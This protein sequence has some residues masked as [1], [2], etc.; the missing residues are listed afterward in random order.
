MEDLSALHDPVGDPVGLRRIQQRVVTRAL[1]DQPG[2]EKLGID[3]LLDV[4]D[5]AV[6]PHRHRVDRVARRPQ[7]LAGDIGQQIGRQAGV[8][9]G[10]A[11]AIAGGVTIDHGARRVGDLGQGSL[12]GQA[13]QRVGEVMA[14]A[15]AD[16]GADQPVDDGALQQH[17]AETRREIGEERGEAVV[18]VRM[19]QD[20]DLLR[21]DQR[22]RGHRRFGQRHVVVP[23]R[24]AKGEELSQVADRRAAGGQRTLRVLQRRRKAQHEVAEVRR[25]RRHRG[26]GREILRPSQDQSGSLGPSGLEGRADSPSTS[27]GRCRSG[28]ASRRR[29]RRA[30]WIS[31]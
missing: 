16:L 18:Q 14:E 1:V 10:I 9:L 27:P 15:V 23:V 12:E 19:D 20:L 24:Q 17:R 6:L 5:P 8:V 31:A 11:A 13:R 7:P 4:R 26:Q 21:R 29:A 30:S 28:P 25:H 2:G 3:D 22:Q